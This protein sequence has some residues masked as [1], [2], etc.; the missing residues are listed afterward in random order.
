MSSKLNQKKKTKKVLKLKKKLQRNLLEKYKEEYSGLEDKDVLNLSEEIVTKLSYSKDLEETEID[1]LEIQLEAIKYII[2]EKSKNTKFNNSDY[3]Y[4]PDYDDPDFNKKIF[5]KKE[6]NLNKIPLIPIPKKNEFFDLKDISNKMCGR[7]EDMVLN[8]NQN[9]LKVFMS[10]STPYNSVLLFHGTGVGKTCSSISIVEEYSE[11]LLRYNKKIIILSNPSIKSNFMK[12]I[13]NVNNV[14]AGR[15]IYQCTKN[16]YFKLLN[17]NPDDIG[18][19]ISFLDFQSK[20]KKK[21]N[22]K[23][24]FNGYQEFANKVEKIINKG[25]RLRPDLRNKYVKEKIKETFSNSVMIIDEAHNI[26]QGDDMK[27]VPPI[28]EKVLKYSENMKLILLSATP[29]F[30]N[31]TEIVWLLNLLLMN[32]K[33][34]LL[35][36]KMLFNKGNL[37]DTGKE[38]LIRKS[39]GYVSYL[40]GENILKFPKRLYPSVYKGKSGYPKS[41]KT[42]EIPKLDLS[43][44]PIEDKFKLKNLEIIGCKMSNH[45]LNYY[46]K[47][48]SSGDYGSFLSNGLM[49]SNIVFPSLSDDESLSNIIGNSGFRNTFSKVKKT[50]NISFKIKHQ[51]FNDMFRLDNLKKYSSKIA[52]IIENIETSEGVVFIYSKYIY[53]GI[54]P[55]ALALEYNGYTNYKSPLL[56]GDKKDPIMI[57]GNSSRKKAKYMI[58]SGTQELGKDAYDDYLKI[59]NKNKNGEMIKVILGSETAAE[60]LDFK[61]IREVHILDPWY[62]L[63]KLEQIIGRAIRYC[64]HIDLPVEKRNVVVNL[65]ASIKTLKPDD[66][67]KETIDLRV[68]R[69]AENKARQMGEVEYI[70]KTN[71][72]D[73]NLNLN[74]NKFIDDNYDGKLRV[75]TPK[76]TNPDNIYIKDKDYDRLCNYSKCDYKCI[77]DLS[78]HRNESNINYDTFNSSTIN[79]QI[80]ILKKN[81]IKMFK[82]DVIYDLEDFT[83]IFPNEDKQII[84]FT[85]QSLLD[86]KDEFTDGYSNVGY[87]IYKG[88]FYIFQPKYLQNHKLNINNIRRP[89]TKKKLGINLNTYIS[90]LRNNNKAMKISHELIINNIRSNY[91][92]LIR[93][94]I[95]KDELWLNSYNIINKGK[96]VFNEEAENSYNFFVYGKIFENYDK[97]KYNIGIGKHFAKTIKSNVYNYGFANDALSFIEQYMER[98][99]IKKIPKNT[100]WSTKI[101]K[102]DDF[103]L[104]LAYNPKLIAN[105][106]NPAKY[107][108]NILLECEIDWLP[109]EEKT[110]LIRHLIE[111]NKD[112]KDLYNLIVKSNLLF[113]KDVYFNDPILKSKNDKQLY[114]YKIVKDK[115]LIYFKYENKTF[116]ECNKQET[117]QIKKST[118]KR[119]LNETYNIM[120]KLGYLEE[121]LPEKKVVL[122]IRDTRGQG[123]KGTQKRKGSICGSDG[124]KKGFITKYLSSFDTKKYNEYSK[125]N[126]CIMIELYLRINHG[127][128]LLGREQ[129]RFYNC[130]ESFEYGIN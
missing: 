21:I 67:D 56:E 75:L 52:K 46:N 68:L 87:L 11:E 89:L 119:I 63:N 58:I 97:N 81:I 99:F 122:K 127:K 70:L 48:D 45:Q 125:Q 130:E 65:Y 85:L 42:S 106:P 95:G 101:D 108:D 18:N 90:S 88:G 117:V 105:K 73:C 16:K 10:P 30:D 12:N 3:K 54:V 76:N 13:F 27:K 78:Q 83:K 92:F 53:S 22:E 36:D 39:R 112:N 2:D 93:D 121:K 9:F 116:T 123:N 14:K 5:L 128:K 41:L 38:L 80:H 104:E 84:Y 24:E 61:N 82:K 86:G 8:P 37:T 102:I 15:P 32:D 34:P 23:Y 43:G 129:H 72:V 20:I 19:K 60:G 79:E 64:S 29:M 62:H 94:N 1:K 33:R 110:I 71:S 47:M 44:N 77:P 118:K 49:L 98:K 25:S 113:N 91:Y 120:D 50:G 74:G 57:N 100:G 35:S 66:E 28:L 40:R 126:L 4:Y 26:K 6:F 96:I 17:L 103:K 31:S 115:K 114:G 124:M 55:L 107:L 59:E 109:Y 111:N 51:E 69:E 7:D